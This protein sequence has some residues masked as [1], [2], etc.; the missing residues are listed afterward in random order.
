MFLLVSLTPTLACIDG[1]SDLEGI[2]F[3]RER[4]DEI[5]NPTFAYQQPPFFFFY[6]KVVG[7]LVLQRS[8]Q[9]L[10]DQ[11]L[12]HAVDDAW[13]AAVFWPHKHRPLLIVMH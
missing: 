3:N 10:T 6:I 8:K 9:N 7:P 12:Q 2:K 5:T 13:V 4:L 11:I 1:L